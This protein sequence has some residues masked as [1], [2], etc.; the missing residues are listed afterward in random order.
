MFIII[1]GNMVMRSVI[2]EKTNRIEIIISSVKPFQLMIG[3]I[4]GTS[5][6]VF[7]SFYMGFNWSFFIVCRICFFELTWGNSRVSRINGTGAARICRYRP[8]V[9][10]GI[11]FTNSEYTNKFYSLFH[12]WLLSLQLF[13]AAIGAA[14]DNQTDHKFLYPLLCL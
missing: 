14:V 11:K 3:K 12:R 5:L 1:Y 9:Y 10:Q 6:E 2:E 4:I 8:N 13:Y 7:F